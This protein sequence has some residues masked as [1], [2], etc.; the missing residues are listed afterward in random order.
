[1]LAHNSRTIESCDC[2]LILEIDKEKWA[3]RKGK[4]KWAK[5]PGHPPFSS[6]LAIGQRFIF[7]RK[8]QISPA[9]NFRL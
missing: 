1:M 5:S 2:D 3:K 8:N 9:S 6:T 7:K 4:E